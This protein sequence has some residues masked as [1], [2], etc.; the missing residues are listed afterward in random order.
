MATS[1]MKK[2]YR[3]GSATAAEMINPI[4]LLLFIVPG[5]IRRVPTAGSAS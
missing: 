4:C 2:E 3:K 5:A 1:P